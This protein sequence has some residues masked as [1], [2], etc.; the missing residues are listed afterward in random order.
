MLKVTKNI[1]T[2]PVNQKAKWAAIEDGDHNASI[3]THIEK[4]RKKKKKK[5]KKTESNAE[6]TKLQ[7]ATK[8]K[9]NSRTQMECKSNNFYGLSRMY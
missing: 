7:T 5:K 9:N 4:K 2:Q 3:K 8:T 6:T 1:T